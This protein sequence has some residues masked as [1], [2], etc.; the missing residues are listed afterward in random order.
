MS[1]PHFIIICQT[2]KLAVY[3]P[4]PIIWCDLGW[5]KW[6]EWQFIQHIHTPKRESVHGR[7]VITHHGIKGDYYDRYCLRCEKT[8]DKLD[9]S[10]VLTRMTQSCEVIGE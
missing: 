6:S 4:A 10:S 7:V 2:C 9:R 5:H 3:P 8:E 1:S